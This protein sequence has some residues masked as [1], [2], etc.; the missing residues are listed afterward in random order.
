MLEQFTYALTMSSAEPAYSVIV[1]AFNEAAQLPQTLTAIAQA[2]RQTARPG[3]LIVVDNNSTDAT[4]ETARQYG[5]Q[6]VFEPHNQISRARNAGAQAARGTWL[7]FVDADTRPSGELLAEA[8][9]QMATHGRHVGGALVAFDRQVFWLGRWTLAMWNTYSRLWREAAGCFL[10]CSRQA[11]EAVGG[12]STKVYASEEL[13]FCKAIKRWARQQGESPRQVVC[14][15]EQPRVV[16]SA[17]KTDRPVR[18]A[19]AMMVML[20]FPPAVFFRRLCGFW[21]RR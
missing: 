9:E 19:L 1:P 7:V 5:A 6:V 8:I 2:M 20:L 13:W 21:Y 4:A 10:F 3:E 16:T 12:F 18:T 11:W 17:R 14:I 15:I